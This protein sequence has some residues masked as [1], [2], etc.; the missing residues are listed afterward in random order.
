[1]KSARKADRVKGR[2][3]ALPGQFSVFS[4]RFPAP[5]GVKHIVG[6]VFRHEVATDVSQ[7][8]RPW[9]DHADQRAL[10]ERQTRVLRAKWQ[11]QI[12][13]PFQGGSHSDQLPRAEVL[14]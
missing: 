11:A 4:F 3:Q 5:T 7:G 10:K 1:M 9:V 2:G 6:R 8:L 13:L 14:G 12:R